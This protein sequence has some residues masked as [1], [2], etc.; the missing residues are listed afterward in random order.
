MKKLLLL[1]CLSAMMSVA[2][3]CGSQTLEVEDSSHVASGKVDFII[4]WNLEAFDAIFRDGCELLEDTPEEVELC[5]NQKISD[6][7][8]LLENKEDVI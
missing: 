3:S 4:D 5:I 8:K 6:L 2:T 1:S 7:L